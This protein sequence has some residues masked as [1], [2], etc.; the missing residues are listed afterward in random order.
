MPNLLQYSEEFGTSPWELEPNVS[1]TA[2]TQTAPDGTTTADTVTWTNA[3]IYLRQRRAVSP[4]V[5]YTFSFYCKRGSATDLKYS[6][7]DWSQAAEIVSPT[8]YYA[9]TN[10]STFT[11][12][13]VTFT[14]PAGCTEV[15]VY[16]VRDPGVTGDAYFWGAQLEPGSSAGAYVKQPGDGWVTT[17]TGPKAVP[18]A[19]AGPSGAGTVGVFV[20]GTA[21]AT[22]DVTAALTGVAATGQAGS[23]GVTRVDDLT[24]VQATGQVGTVTASLSKALTGV[25][26]SGDVGAVAP[27]SSVSLNGVAGSG[28]AGSVGVSTTV[29]LTGVQAT[30]GVGTV[31][32]SFET[33]VAL[34][35][36]SGAG[37]IAAVAPASVVP[38]SGASGGGQVGTVIPT[39]SKAVAG[40][41]TTGA[42]GSTGVQRT[43]T[44]AGAQG[45]GEVG[46]VSILGDVTIALS[47]VSATGHVGS[48]GARNDSASQTT[49]GWPVLPR[50]KRATVRQD[51][52]QEEALTEPLES[53]DEIPARAPV[54]SPIFVDRPSI[55]YSEQELLQA[56]QAVQRQIQAAMAAE[57]MQDEEEA[58]LLLLSVS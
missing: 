8:T 55:R 5:Q 38:L 26:G 32:P 53:Q 56:R 54:Q 17:G 57:E 34:T 24:G 40:I 14:A 23:V 37:Q 43:V 19:G 45:L 50:K 7:Y 31:T 39:T 44:L 27:Q 1:V 20:R 51:R 3:L 25:G 33:I 35:G 21:S 48:V 42:V 13:S 30:G 6:V 16:P 9:S 58:L 36:V 22:S 15:A 52:A 46:S 29:G 47:G 49:G 12:I 18:A 11:R 41:Q 4:G 28:Q 10:G 2:D